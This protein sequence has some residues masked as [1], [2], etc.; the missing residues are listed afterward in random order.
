MLDSGA[1]SGE[2]E[3]GAMSAPPEKPKKSRRLL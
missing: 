3:R 2:D 1:E